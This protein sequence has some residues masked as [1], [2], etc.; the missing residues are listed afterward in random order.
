MVENTGG[1]STKQLVILG[2]LVCV[3]IAI[4]VPHFIAKPAVKGTRVGIKGQPPLPPNFDKMPP[5][6]KEMIL[7]S[8]E[9]MA[10]QVR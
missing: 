8:R 6:L 9:R 2:V 5:Q 3:L 1:T 10:K 4:L 7:K